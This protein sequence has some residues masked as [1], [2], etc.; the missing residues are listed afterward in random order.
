MDTPT[1]RRLGSR[2][3]ARRSASGVAVI[4]RRRLLT[5]A[6]FGALLVTSPLTVRAHDIPARVAVLAFV[7]PEAGHLRLLV[8]VPLEGTHDVVSP[9]LP[10]GG[11]DIDR[12]ERLTPDAPRV[13]IAEYAEV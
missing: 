3:T 1:L 4:A 2:R 9:A 7:K 11:L 8:R 10:S 5:G 13:W 12:A 6:V